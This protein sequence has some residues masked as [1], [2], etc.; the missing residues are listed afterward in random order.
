MGCYTS[1]L[2]TTAVSVLVWCHLK[3]IPGSSEGSLHLGGSLTTAVLRSPAFR[4][5]GGEVE[6]T[7]ESVNELNKKDVNC[8][9]IRASN[10]GAN[11]P[12]RWSRSPI[13]INKRSI[14]LWRWDVKPIDIN[15]CVCM[16][17][18]FEE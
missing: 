2:C 13:H 18:C 1:L 5:G 12:W 15:I 9:S 11:P 4:V 6:F 10:K 17:V 16:Y 3:A 7:Y 14:F 8:I